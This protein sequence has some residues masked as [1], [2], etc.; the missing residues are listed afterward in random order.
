MIMT[1]SE[2][3]IPMPEG[4]A[5]K[6]HKTF[7][8]AEIEPGFPYYLITVLQAPEYMFHRTFLLSQIGQVFDLVDRYAGEIVSIQK[9]S[10]DQAT[11]TSFDFD[12]VTCVRKSEK[13][14]YVMFA[15]GSDIRTDHSPDQV[16]TDVWPAFRAPC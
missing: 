7:S 6:G 11:S 12:L 1:T 13:H 15:D 14:W 9:M 4:L 16:W 8:Y 3:E 10:F 2:A 5:P